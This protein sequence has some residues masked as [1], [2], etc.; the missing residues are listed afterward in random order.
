L[1]EEA[2]S[3]ISI[4]SSWLM[5]SPSSLATRLML[6]TLMRPV[7]SSSNRSKILLMPLYV[8]VI[9][10]LVSLSPNLEVMASKNYSKSISRP[11]PYKSAI[12]W[13]IVGFFDSKPRLCI[14][15]LSSLRQTNLYLGSILPVPSVS[16]RLKASRISSIS[17]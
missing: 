16:N 14:A 11:W 6:F 10:T 17:S 4:S 8:R 13:K 2:R 9:D 1:F 3:S 7:P 5:V 12:I 15:A